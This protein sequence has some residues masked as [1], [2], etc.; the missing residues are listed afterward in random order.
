MLAEYEPVAGRD[1]PVRSSFCR[2]LGSLTPPK[3]LKKM[4]TLKQP[5]RVE[6]FI[7]EG[8]E[9]ANGPMGRRIYLVS[10]DR[11][12]RAVIVIAGG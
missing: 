9:T 6:G 12:D 7:F 11:S 1:D 10:R 8:S 5:P 3:L 4:H 2:Y